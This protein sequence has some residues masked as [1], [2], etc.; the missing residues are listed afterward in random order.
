MLPTPN[1]M[2]EHEHGH[3]FYTSLAA[4]TLYIYVPVNASVGLPQTR[5]LDI[6]PLKI[7]K[8]MTTLTARLLFFVV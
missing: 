3:I 5:C 8:H 6:T 2:K 4:F 7:I 1:S